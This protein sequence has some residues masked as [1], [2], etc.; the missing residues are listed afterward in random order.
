MKHISAL[1]VGALLFASPSHAETPCDFKGISVGNKMAPADVMAALGVT[2]YK[3]NPAQPP[4]GETL[5]LAQKYGTIPAAELK[6]WNIGPYCDETSCRVPYGVAVGNN[7]TPVNVFISFHE[8]R[9]TEIDVSFSETYWDEMLPILHQKYGA[10]WR[11]DRFDMPI[12]NYETKKS[13]MRE[14]ISLDHIANGLN[15][16]TND[17]CQIWATNIDLMFEHHDAFGPYHSVFGIKLISK[18]F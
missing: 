6:D 17:R 11:V 14:I 1:L 9:I 13:I 7:N 10:D 16:S 2:K 8:G 4:F 5:A 15:R 12:M 3:T 18:N